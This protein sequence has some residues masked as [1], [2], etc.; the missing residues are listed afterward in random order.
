MMMK[1]AALSLLLL[2]SCRATPATAAATDARQLVQC[3]KKA[4]EKHRFLAEGHRYATTI[5]MDRT[6]RALEASAE[7]QADRE[8]IANSST[9]I[10]T[11]ADIESDYD[12]ALQECT[13]DFEASPSDGFR[14]N[15]NEDTF[16]STEEFRVECRALGGLVYQVDLDFDCVFSG[17]EQ[18]VDF[19]VSIDNSD[20]CEAP[21]C[22]TEEDVADAGSIISDLVQDIE[23]QVASLGDGTVSAECDTS[24]TIR[25]ETGTVVFRSGVLGVHMATSLMGVA[26]ATLTFA[27]W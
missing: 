14:C 20:A 25:D 5:T 2:A 23:T 6:T 27:I 9:L 10:D 7:C 26:M 16:A 3:A 22:T 17:P 19:R 15:I 8:A 11:L 21:S 24:T 4:L 1:I 12:A 13:D 18:S